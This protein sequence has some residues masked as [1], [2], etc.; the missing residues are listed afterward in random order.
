MFAEVFTVLL[1][2]IWGTL[3]INEMKDL[4]GSDLY[5]E[6]D[7]TFGQIIAIAL[8]SSSLLP[9]FELLYIFSFEAKHLRTAFNASSSVFALTS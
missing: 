6:N 1:S 8:L 7:W 5:E 3:S 2:A 4:G 9:I